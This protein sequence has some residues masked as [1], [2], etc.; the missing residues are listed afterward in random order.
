MRET[1]MSVHLCLQ[2]T[3]AVPLPDRRMHSWLKKRSSLEEGTLRFNKR[4]GKEE[5][6]CWAITVCQTVGTQAKVC[7]ETCNTASN[8]SGSIHVLLHTFKQCKDDT[9]CWKCK[10]ALVIGHF[11]L[12]IQM[13]IL[14]AKWYHLS[15]SL[16]KDSVYHP[17]LLYGKQYGTAAVR[18]VGLE[19]AASR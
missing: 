19:T 11:A 12:R 10:E 2:D 3:T 17:S 9:E 13:G 6:I 5:V 4:D 7:S 1:V 16:R 8:K 14:T 15:R 18:R